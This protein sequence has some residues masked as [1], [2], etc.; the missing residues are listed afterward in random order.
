MGKKDENAVCLSYKD[1]TF[2][3]GLIRNMIP[4]PDVPMF[5]EIFCEKCQGLPE[6]CERH[7]DVAKSKLWPKWPN[8][9]NN[10]LATL[11]EYNTRVGAQ[12][13]KT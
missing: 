3:D 5:L 8:L 12:S 1:V 10:V 11:S 13:R 4:D 7:E 2:E 9:E 6:G